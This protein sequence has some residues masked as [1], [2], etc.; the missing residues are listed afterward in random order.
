MWDYDETFADTGSFRRMAKKHPAEYA[1]CFRNMHKVKGILDTGKRIGG[2]R[3]NF[4]RSEGGG[5][6][7]IGQTGVNAAKE[8]RL[9]VHPDEKKQ[10]IYILGIGAK[11]RQEAD[12]AKYRSTVKKVREYDNGRATKIDG[13]TRGKARGGTGNEGDCPTGN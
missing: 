5:V 6:Y 9:Y 3:L 4:F 1:A 13:G 2:F 7:R 11:D 8:M 12:I 10:R